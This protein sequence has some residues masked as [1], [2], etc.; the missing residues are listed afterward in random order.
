MS[1]EPISYS[2]KG[3]AEATGLSPKTLERAIKNKRLP[4]GKSTID[5]DGNPSGVWVIRADDLRAFVDEL[6]EAS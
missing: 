4:A 3:A 2:L 1:V 5:E 6:V